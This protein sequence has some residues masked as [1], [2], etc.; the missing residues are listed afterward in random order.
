[1]KELWNRCSV[2]GIV[3]KT[4]SRAS[5]FLGSQDGYGTSGGLA[6][7]RYFLFAGAWSG[8][9]TDFPTD[10]EVPFWSVAC[11]DGNEPCAKTME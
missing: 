3:S 9:E 7:R 1:M 6:D 11:L 2:G 5:G 4:L 10:V 8:L